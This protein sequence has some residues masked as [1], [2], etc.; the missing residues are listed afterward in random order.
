M[1]GLGLISTYTSDSEDDEVIKDNNNKSNEVSE[2]LPLP[3]SIAAWKGVP[4]HEELSDDPSQHNGRIR[5]FK[6]ERG[7]WATLVYIDYEPSET[8]LLWMLSVS[9][10]L[11]MKCNIFSE[12]FH[13]SITRTLI[14]KFHWIESFVEEIKKLCEQT[15]QFRLEFLNVRT[16]CNE[17]KTR[18]FLGIECVDYK[19]TLDNFVKDINNS[20]VEYKLPP[21]YE[22]SSYHISF[23]WCLGD[24]TAS[25]SNLT[26]SLTNKL[27][28]YLAEHIEE[29]YIHINKVH[30][31][32]GNRLYAFKLR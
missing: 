8:M 5:S 12:E 10:E 24:E 22:D 21:F 18:T 3:G 25:L 9:N 29:R 32:V 6:H 20:L 4:H 2:R 1:S 19:G 11:P 13:I 26:S 14:L 23:L 15:N 31:K 17:E 7:N 16:Y 27:N 30:L 28:H